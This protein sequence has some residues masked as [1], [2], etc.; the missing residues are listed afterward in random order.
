MQRTLVLRHP[1]S[2]ANTNGTLLEISYAVEMLW[3]ALGLAAKIIFLYG[4]TT[5]NP[6]PWLI[7][8][9]GVTI[10]VV[11]LLPL[12]GLMFYDSGGV[13]A[14]TEQ[15]PYVDNLTPPLL[16]PVYS[17][18]IE[19]SV[20]SWLIAVL[21]IFIIGNWALGH[22]GECCN[23]SLDVQEDMDVYAGYIVSLSVLM[24][25]DIAG[26]L[27]ISNAFI[28]L[29]QLAETTITVHVSENDE[30]R[31]SL[32]LPHD[33]PRNAEICQ[34]GLDSNLNSLSITLWGYVFALLVDALVLIFNMVLLLTGEWTSTQE[35][36]WSWYAA[37]TILTLLQFLFVVLGYSVFINSTFGHDH[38]FAAT[39]HTHHSSVHIRIHRIG[40]FAS[41]MLVWG[42]FLLLGYL[43]ATTNQTDPTIRAVLLGGTALANVGISFAVLAWHLPAAI[44]MFYPECVIGKTLRINSTYQQR[45]KNE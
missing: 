29:K 15:K 24:V 23:T 17:G 28:A 38:S 6:W 30:G 8:Y 20:M 25:L 43:L 13:C 22:A 19:M 21:Q 7:V 41:F 18:T 33:I 10:V 42:S 11:I 3:F 40:V 36:L 27:M 35:V 26:M 16:N 32:G 1:Y 4:V 31:P 5:L 44:S 39:H 34:M 14:Q 37:L 2:C 12:F 45:N 9:A